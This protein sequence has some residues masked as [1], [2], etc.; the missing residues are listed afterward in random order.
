MSSFQFTLRLGVF[1]NRGRTRRRFLSVV[2]KVFEFLANTKCSETAGLVVVVWLRVCS[3]GYMYI[4]MLLA[5]FSPISFPIDAS[6][7]V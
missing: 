1:L 5:V 7:S 6:L 2:V 3:S 4:I